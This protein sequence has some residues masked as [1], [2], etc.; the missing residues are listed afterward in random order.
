MFSQCIAIAMQFLKLSTAKAVRRWFRRAEDTK[1]LKA[2]DGWCACN[3]QA[4][5]TWIMEKWII[6]RG[7]YINTHTSVRR[8]MGYHETFTATPKLPENL[9]LIKLKIHHTLTWHG[10]IS[11]MML[12]QLAE[13]FT[14]NQEVGWNLH[15]IK[16]GIH[17]RWNIISK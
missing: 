11:H 14:S 5:I 4:Q 1:E 15:T 16:T 3:C 2:W 12:T 17:S 13:I 6:N 8:N 9:H 7:K 10:H